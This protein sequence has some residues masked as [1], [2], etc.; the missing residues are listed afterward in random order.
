MRIPIQQKL[1]LPTLSRAIKTF[2]ITYHKLSSQTIHAYN[3]ITCANVFNGFFCRNL[4]IE[5]KPL[6]SRLNLNY[7]TYMTSYF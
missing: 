6:I 3:H 4:L 7:C 2:K 1:P 5:T